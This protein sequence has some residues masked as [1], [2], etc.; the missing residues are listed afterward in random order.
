MTSQTS[1]SGFAVWSLVLG[2]LSLAVIGVGLIW[3]SMTPGLAGLPIGFGA[4]LTTL[5]IAVIGLIVAALAHRRGARPRWM[6][7]V[8][9]VIDSL[10]LLPTLF[11]L[12]GILA[13]QIS[14][15]SGSHLLYG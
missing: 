10:A 5:P 15:W 11:I 6:M 2:C 12:A 1:P 9:I 4:A 8:G 14:L 13:L 3:S 7:I